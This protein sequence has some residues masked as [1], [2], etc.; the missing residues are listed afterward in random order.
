MHSIHAVRRESSP[1]GV[2]Y[3][4]HVGH[5]PS[6]VAIA[7][8]ACRDRTSSASSGPRASPILRRPTVYRCASVRPRPPTCPSA[9][10]EVECAAE[11]SPGHHATIVD[12][13]R[14]KQARTT[15]RGADDPRRE[16]L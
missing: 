6:R 8:D 7:A 9:R 14:V 15:R 1:R 10:G 3:I 2:D 16:L 13:M 5:S 12:A 4:H 11:K